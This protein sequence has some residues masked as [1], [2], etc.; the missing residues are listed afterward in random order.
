MLG[1]G[2]TYT[3]S[4][5][6]FNGCSQGAFYGD[7]AQ[8]NTNYPLVRIT[9]SAA[10]VFYAKTHDHTR[11]GVEAVSDNATLVSTNLMFRLPWP[12]ET[13]RWWVVTNGFPSDP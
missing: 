5:F 9:D 11:M 13:L 6:H 7:D 12:R 3:I 8:S 10:H 4:G 1:L 2:N